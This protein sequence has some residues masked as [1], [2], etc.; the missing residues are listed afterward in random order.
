MPVVE[1]RSHD[2]G[3]EEV[4]VNRLH[5]VHPASPFTSTLCRRAQPELQMDKG[6]GQ[7]SFW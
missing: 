7:R 5:H 6:R 2:D 3:A 4:W 1:L